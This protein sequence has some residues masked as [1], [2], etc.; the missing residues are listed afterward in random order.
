VPLDDDNEEET[1]TVSLMGEWDQN[2][3]DHQAN[4]SA[5]RVRILLITYLLNHSP[6]DNWSLGRVTMNTATFLRWA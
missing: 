2:G 1:Q 3:E 5:S 6:W 4:R